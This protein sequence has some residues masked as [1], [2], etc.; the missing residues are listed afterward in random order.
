LKIFTLRPLRWDL[1][2]CSLQL[3]RKELFDYSNRLVF[4]S[5]RIA[6]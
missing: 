6:A 4:L 5:N 3:T 1:N 2:R